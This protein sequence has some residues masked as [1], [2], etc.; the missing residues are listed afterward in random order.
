MQLM[1]MPPPISSPLPRQGKIRTTAP[2]LAKR[3]MPLPSSWPPL[4][5]GRRPPVCSSPPLSFCLCIQPALA[6]GCAV[7]PSRSLESPRGRHTSKTILWTPEILPLCRW[8]QLPPHL[9]KID[10]CLDRPWAQH[11]P[12]KQNPYYAPPH[13]R[14]IL[15]SAPTPCARACLAL[16][17]GKPI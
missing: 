6:T 3:Y 2:T 1:P 12:T 17:P 15:H 13:G 4:A 10:L 8:I 14:D 11:A 5:P 7:L 9:Q 16:S